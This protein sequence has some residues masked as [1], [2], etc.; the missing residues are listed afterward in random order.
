MTLVRVSPSLH[1]PERISLRERAAWAL[2]SVVFHLLMIVALLLVPRPDRPVEQVRFVPLGEGVPEAGRIV[3]L[4]PTP[5]A[6]GAGPPL[7]T[8]GTRA[9]RALPT[10]AVAQVPERRP[11]ARGEPGRAVPDTLAPVGEVAIGRRRLLRPAYGDGR[12]WVPPIDVLQLG[13]RLPGPEGPV[14]ATPGVE[15]L[16]RLVTS[17][18]MAFLDSLPPDS[19]APPEAPRWTTEIAGRTWGVDGQWIYLG[20]LKL[21]AAL[22]ALLPLPEGGYN[23]D[24]ARAAG[25]LQR[26]RRDLL[27]AAQ[28]AE[29]QAEFNRYVRELRAR[30]DAEREAQRRM[31]RDTIIP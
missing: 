15:T 3:Y 24:Q 27:Q 7:P 2:A 29:T 21:P 23:F 8:P 9:E 19:F 17:R 18:L 13:R 4:V 28:R 14:A 5:G 25:E 10:P 20:D 11:E 31:P 1:P 16:E 26:M 30:K 12:L 22:L 6:E